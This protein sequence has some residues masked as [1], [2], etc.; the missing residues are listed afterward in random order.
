MTEVNEALKRPR[1]IASIEARMGST[2]L[3]GKVLAD[4]RGKPALSR[5]LR[6]LRRCESL[7]GMILATSVDPKDDPVAAWAAAEGLPC[8]RGSEEDVLQRVVEAQRRMDSEV[9]VEVCGDMTLLDPELIDL[10]VE[11]FLANACDV[12]TT[13]CKPSFP[14]GA[15][16]L[17]CR[18]SDLEWVVRNVPDPLMHEHVALYL[19]RHPER[20]RVIHLLA[21]KGLRAPERRFVL[22]YPEDLAFI[23]AVYDRLAPEYG[24]DFGIREILSLLERDPA[25]GEI[26]R[27]LQEASS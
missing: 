21:P 24:E 23:R 6:R 11:T 13:T 2:R 14:V 5:L 18:L 7:D 26:N 4:V 16:V 3:P 10:G 20:Y 12:V 27:H 25:L 17:V 19:L 1:I 22:D 9:V 8:H 15:D